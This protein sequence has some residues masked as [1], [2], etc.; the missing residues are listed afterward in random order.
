MKKHF[1]FGYNIITFWGKLQQL[2]S[3][4]RIIFLLD[5]LEGRSFTHKGVLR[6]VSIGL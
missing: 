6:S 2:F 5:S 3:K 4:L 1:S